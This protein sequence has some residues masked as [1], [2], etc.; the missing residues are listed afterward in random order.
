MKNSV[1]IPTYNR[2]GLAENLKKQILK[3]APEVEIII[4]DQSN[5][6]TPNTSQAKNQGISKARGEIL[7][8]LDDDVEI[9]PSTIKAHLHEYKDPNVLA[10][11]GRVI[12]DGETVP[13]NTDVETGKMNSLGTSFIKNFWGERKQTVVHPYGCNWSVRRSVLDKVGVFDVLFPPPLSSFEEIDLGLRISQ[14]GTM[15]F[16]PEALVFHH[17]AQSGGTRVDKVTRNKLYY[18]SYGRL[19]KKHIKFPLILVSIAI[20]KIRIIKEA[21]YSLISFF[22]GL[23]CM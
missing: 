21:P 9:T 3:F 10:V 17:R 14:I 5:S 22:K 4:V 20:I 15:I 16:S 11:A 8:F 12:N 1:V 13:E 18:Q 23:F 2:P 6:N 7:I 19:I